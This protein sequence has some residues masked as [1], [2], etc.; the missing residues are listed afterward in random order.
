MRVLRVCM[1]VGVMV[2]LAGAAVAQTA[3]YGE[4][5]GA[6]IGANS[7]WMFGPTVGVYHDAG[8]GLLAAGYDVRGTYVGRGD[9]AGPNSDLK[10]A[11]V[12]VGVRLAVTPRVLPIKPYGE[13]LGGLGHLATGVGPTRTSETKFAYAIVGG[14]DL[15]VLPRVDWR[16]LEF[17]YERLAGVGDNYSPKSLSMGIVFR[18]P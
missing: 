16:V 17:S 1:L 4:L 12:L 8:Y 2:G 5:T 15:T 3:I 9:V 7:N 13:V 11:S 14:V 10:L 6:K 18:L